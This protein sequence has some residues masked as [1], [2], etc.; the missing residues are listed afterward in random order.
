MALQKPINCLKPLVIAVVAWRFAPA[1]TRLRAEPRTALAPLNHMLRRGFFLVQGFLI[2]ALLD[3]THWR[4][5][6]KI[7]ETQKPSVFDPQTRQA[8]AKRRPGRFDGGMA[9]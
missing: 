7:S 5:Y 8:F 9:S 1:A 4:A 3:G 6:R 2:C